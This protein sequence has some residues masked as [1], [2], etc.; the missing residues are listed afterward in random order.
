MAVDMNSVSIIGRLTRDPELAYT[1]SQVA[2]CR[3]S[4]ANNRIGAGNQEEVNFFD[5][6][7]WDKLATT[8]SQYLRKGRQVGI[9][10]RLSQNR[11]QDKQTGANRSKIEI[12]ALSVQ[13]IG[14]QDGGSGDYNPPPA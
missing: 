10:G 8:C 9:L 4:V 13:F 7:T 14:G 12:V 2:V 1:Q 11:F 6:V 3:F 5:I